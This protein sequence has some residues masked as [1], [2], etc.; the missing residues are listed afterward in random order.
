MQSKFFLF[1]SPRAALAVCLQNVSKSGCL[2][3][4]ASDLFYPRISLSPLSLVPNTHKHTAAH[5]RGVLHTQNGGTP[6]VPRC[7]LL[8][9][10][11]EMK[12]QLAFSRLLSLLLL[13]LQ[14]AAAECLHSGSQK[15]V[16][17]L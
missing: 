3:R 16:R 4:G 14:I 10:A 2:L 13:L 8:L 17:G 12:E 6:L 1:I 7:R 11:D 5:T 9:K 15:S